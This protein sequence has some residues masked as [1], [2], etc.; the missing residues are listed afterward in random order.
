L[1]CKFCN[2]EMKILHTLLKYYCLDCN[3]VHAEYNG[4]SNS[5][6]KP[7]SKFGIQ[8]DFN[9][10][11]TVLYDNNVKEIIFS[12]HEILDVTPDNFEQ[13]IERLKK[14]MVFS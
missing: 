1:I 14:L 12:I 11:K 10:N 5:F 6:A 4:V 8:L 3:Y 9:Q 2:K 7:D 13:V